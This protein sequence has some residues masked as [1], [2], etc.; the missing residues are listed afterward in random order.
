MGG[1]L[2]SFT[3]MAVAVRELLPA[4][5]YFEILVLRSGACLVLL[6]P[7][8]AKSGLEPLRTRRP[9][10]H[11]LR[12]LFHLAGQYAWVYALAALPLATVFALEFT[13]P[14]WAA[15][16]A[17]LLLGERLRLGR[18]V[19]LLTGFAGIAIIL[20]P[21][22]EPIP[23][24]ALV[25]LAGSFCYG[26]AIIAA[27]RLADTDSMMAILFYMSAIQLPIALVLAASRWTM[28]AAADL[29]WV[30][31]LGVAGLSA[32]FCMTRAFRVADATLVVP[33]DF[34]RLPLIAAI[35]VLFYG[36]PLELTVLLGAAV[37]F[38]G[39]YY[40][41]RRESRGN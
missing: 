15:L 12:S 34:L 23:P 30:A 5:G 14:V 6:L 36:E 32:H 27:K 9:G 3:L 33:I 18:L 22:A 10:L 19:M 39:T 28:P 2:L 41:I 40:C 11:A 7:V 31:A 29:P 17:M 1:A 16:L 4:H 25:M 13:M 21:G 26:A 38:S 8:L 20:R 37:M 24:A 35:G